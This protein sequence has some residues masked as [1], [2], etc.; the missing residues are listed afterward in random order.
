MLIIDPS[1]D[2]HRSNPWNKGILV[3]QN[4]PPKPRDVWTAE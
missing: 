2:L 3:G 4:G 1:T